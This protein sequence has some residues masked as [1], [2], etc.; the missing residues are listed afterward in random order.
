MQFFF[1]LLI[2]CLK[3]QR[4]ISLDIMLLRVEKHGDRTDERAR[5]TNLG[6]L[7]LYHYISSNTFVIIFVH[8]IVV[9]PH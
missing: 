8:Y 2:I 7:S 5:Y 9:V 6:K 1:V 4:T 3:K